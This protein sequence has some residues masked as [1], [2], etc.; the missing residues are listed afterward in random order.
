MQPRAAVG[1]YG[2][3]V[4]VRHLA[5]CGYQVLAR[6]WRCRVGEIDV[7]ALDGPVVVVCEVK[8]RRSDRFGNPLEAVT[9][10]KAARLRRLAVAY[11]GD[12]GLSGRPIRID[13]IGV[14]LPRRGAPRLHHLRGVG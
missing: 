6:N 1:R 5:A 14:Q 2:E 7:V 8:T 9:P 11:V 4:A 3:D 13:L 10:A 12:H